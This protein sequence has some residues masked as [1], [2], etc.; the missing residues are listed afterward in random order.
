[1]AKKTAAKKKP[2]T[3]KAAARAS[4]LPD[5][6]APERRPV[7]E[8]GRGGSRPAAATPADATYDLSQPKGAGIRVRATAM[9]YYGDARR[10]EGDIFTIANEREF[11]SRW[12][13][14]VSPKAR[15]RT[16]TGKQALQKHHDETNKA[17]LGLDT[18]IDNPEGSEAVLGE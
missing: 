11:S 2:A 12:M 13:E 7:V 18:D 8:V 9:G 6:P 5:A 1:M 14:R 3:K 15:E 4:K 16:T 10:R 17:R